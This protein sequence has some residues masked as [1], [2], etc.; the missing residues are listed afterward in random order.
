MKKSMLFAAAAVVA[1][2]GCTNEDFTGFQQSQNGEAAINFGS[3]GKTVTRAEKSGK[4]AAQDLGENF[5][6]MGFKGNKTEQ[7][8][9]NATKVFDFYNVNWADASAG[10]T[11]SNSKNWEYVGQAVNALTSVKSQTIKYWDFALPQYDFIAFSKGKNTKDVDQYF[12]DFNFDNVGVAAAAGTDNTVYTITGTLDELQNCYVA[13]IITVKA[14]KYGTEAV[15]PRFRRMQSKIRLGFYETVPGYSVKNV[16]FYK[17]ADNLAATKEN[18]TLYGSNLAVKGSDA[19][20][21]MKVSYPTVDADGSAA[22]TTADP[23]NNQAHISFEVA[24]GSTLSSTLDFK[25]LE[26]SAAQADEEAGNKY[27]GRTS[28]TATYAGK[29]DQANGFAYEVVLPTSEGQPLYLKVNYTLVSIDGSGEEIKVTGATA[30]VPA[31]YTAWQPNFAYTYLFK[32]SDETNGK[33]NPTDFPDKAGLY[34]ITFDAVIEGDI[35]GVQET[36]TKVGDYAITT[37]QQG[38]VVTENDEY[39]A[40]ENIYVTVDNGVTLSSNSYEGGYVNVYKATTSASIQDI[41]EASV[42]NCYEQKYDPTGATTTFTTNTEVNGGTLTLTALECGADKSWELLSAIPNDEAPHGVE[43]PTSGAET[44][45]AR[46]NKPAKGVYVF[47]YTPVINPDEVFGTPECKTLATAAPYYSLAVSTDDVDGTP[48]TKYTYTLESAAGNEKYEAN[49]Y[50]KEAPSLASLTA[51]ANPN[52]LKAGDKFYKKSGDT[53]TEFI[54]KGNEE[55]TSGLY[56]TGT[57][58]HATSID[59]GD[60]YYVKVNNNYIEKTATADINPTTSDP[61]YT[62][63]FTE[64]TAGTTLMAG[65]TYI[66]QGSSTLEILEFVSTGKETWVAGK[67]YNQAKPDDVELNATNDFNTLSSDAVV[68]TITASSGKM[69]AAPVKKTTTGAETS[70]DL[71]ANDK[72]Y[73]KAPKSV[74]KVIRV[75]Q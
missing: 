29:N 62:A 21:V 66:T 14:A 70:T 63:T 23:D 45:V 44:Q 17:D 24:S 65:E 31:I 38:K 22:G 49:K 7:L 5:V 69:T 74:Y 67:Y 2:V 51:A 59:D 39:K 26:Y 61:Y 53:Y 19:M 1:M 52:T 12:A 72:V 54:A 42:A 75:A 58:V 28:A 16:E 8:A 13:D 71:T 41:T 6:V 27:L 20:G 11:E 33:T 60:T 32:I 34:P 10:S 48:A 3:V 57:P 25:A 64:V 36:I 56:Y 68:Y 30:V 50:F 40:S 37:Y 46:I 4:D 15:T 47:Q 55:I 9:S 35:D 73:V 43:I 18:A